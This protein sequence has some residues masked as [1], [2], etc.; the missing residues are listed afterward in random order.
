MTPAPGSV[1][2]VESDTADRVD[3]R[4]W[5]IAGV[6]FLGPFMAQMDSTI[7][8][9]S[10]SSIRDALHSTITAAHWIISGY[11]LAL[12]LTL[13][14]NG[15]L[16]DRVGT[17]R[18]YLG[19]FSAFTVASVLCGASPSMNT[20]ILAR[21]FQGVAG[22]LLAP[23]TQLM[24][25]R[26]AGN[27]MARVMGFTVVPVLLAP[28][29]G[30]VFAG[31]ILKYAGW[32]WL[33][34]VNLPVGI[35]AVI[36]AAVLLPG[37]DASIDKRRFDLRGFLLISPGLVC[38]LYGVDQVPGWDGILILGA[39]V[40]LAGVF[41]R[42]ALRAPKSALIDLRLFRNRV[43]SISARTQFLANGLAYAGQLLIPLY[44]TVG[45]GLSPA[46]AGWKLAPMGLGM[47]F[48]Y[49]MMGFLNEKF[50]CRAVAAGGAAIVL[51]GTL[52]FLW[53]IHSGLSS[54]LLAISLVTRGAGQGAI[55]IPSLSA[56][57]AAVPRS[58]LAAATT[59]INIV[60]RLGGPIATTA[61]ALVISSASTR[62]P[63]GGSSAFLI[64]FAALIGLQV[65]VLTSAARLPI[66]IEQIR[67]QA[68][69]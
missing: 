37:D 35:L 65:F 9:F 28:L 49:P 24:I 23:M 45:C 52:P 18:L 2:A 12:A 60:Q 40:I 68:D 69:E 26:A 3:P 50:G 64:P 4:V 14:L 27:Q 46:E 10:L 58:R 34:Y 8:N 29:L 38:L 6:A 47:M 57:Y 41:A 7:V 43:F 5:R 36:L 31:A 25:A 42:H 53:M 61:L 51:V 15:W 13:P 66:R 19:C 62:D 1:P 17:K 67:R 55:G 39:G 16:V 32:P 21:V 54:T 63:G 56:A 44:L 11:L 59:A 22:G 20:L 33:F 30:P 48:T